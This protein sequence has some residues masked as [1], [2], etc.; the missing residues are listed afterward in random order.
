MELR[1]AL[2]DQPV[3]METDVQKVQQ[4]LMNLLI[5]AIKFT[6]RGRVELSAYP[7]NDHVVFSVSDTGIGIPPEDFERIFEPFTQL[8]TGYT[9]TVK[10]TGL[11][12]SICRH[13]L[14]LLGGEIRVRSAPREGS[15]FTVRV[16]SR[17][18]PAAEN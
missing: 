18:T 2:P 1:L 7:E 5:N 16:P 12:L 3:P 8:D 13:M 11:G 6:E 14:G 10:G 9:R 4:V 15:T 17:L